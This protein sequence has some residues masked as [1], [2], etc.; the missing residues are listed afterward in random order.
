MPA[1]P[2]IDDRGVP[3]CTES[4]LEHDGKR[5]KLLGA[6]PGNLCEPEVAIMAGT[7]NDLLEEYYNV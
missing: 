5:C 7:L 3:Y 4:C 1:Q 6:R 2:D